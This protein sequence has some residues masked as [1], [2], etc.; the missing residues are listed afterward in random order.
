MLRKV[1][2]IASIEAWNSEY[3]QKMTHNLV[4]YV[5][6]ISIWKKNKTGEALFN[7]YI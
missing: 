6:V 2:K 3:G 5:S 1:S 7:P 4:Q